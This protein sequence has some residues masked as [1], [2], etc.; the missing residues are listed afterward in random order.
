MAKPIDQFGGWLRF[1]EVTLYLRIF[2]SLIFLGI[3]IWK[4]EIPSTIGGWTFAIELPLF[5][6]IGSWILT[7]IHVKNPETPKLILKLLKVMFVFSVV[8]LGVTLLALVTS[9][10]P[11]QRDNIAHSFFPA[12]G[13]IFSYAIW[14]A[15]FKQSVRVSKYYGSAE[16][17]QELA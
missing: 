2:L 1:F 12:V 5:I 3:L 17:P 6:F 8:V 11:N 4:I 10:D 9:T 7:R 13:R 15:Y 14:I 16:P